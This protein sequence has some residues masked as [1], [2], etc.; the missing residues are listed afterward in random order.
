[1]LR[2]LHVKDLVIV[3][4]LALEL[5][6]GM[7]ALTGETGAGKSIL[8]DALG[9]A[10][11]EKAD[12]A[13]IRA[14]RERAEVA[15]VFDVDRLPAVRQWL[16]ERDLGTA[17]CILRRVVPREGRSRAFVNGSPVPVQTLRELG[18]LL[19]DIHGQHAHQ[20]LLH[21]A[22]QRQLLDSYAGH[23][24]A[25][26]QVAQRYADYRQA[27]RQLDDLTAAAADRAN[28][29]DFL[30]YQVQEL[31]HGAQPAE[32]L[33]ALDEEQRRLAHAER[34]LGDTAALAESL[35][36]ADDAVQ[37]VLARAV[38]QLD[39]LL[40]F[41]PALS[42][43]RELLE[44]ARIQVEEAA[45]TL[46]DYAGRIELDPERLQQVE[47]QLERIHQLAR[48]HRVPPAGL[49]AHLDALRGE[50]DRLQHADET[51]AAL[52]GRAETLQRDY[53]EA[54]GKLSDRR[55]RAGQRLAQEVTAA[56]QGLAMRGGRFDVAVRPLPEAQAGAQG[57]DE[58]EFLVTANPGQPL[59]PLSR[60]ASGGE[61]SRIS[62]AIQVASAGCGEVP[63][64][65]FDE[66]DVGIG[67][68]VAEIVGRLLRQLGE[69]RQVLCVTHLPQ[70]AAQSHQHLQVAKR[71]DGK[72][73]E[74]GIAPLEAATRIQ[75]I[76]RMLGGVDI[77]EQT[78]AHAAEMIGRAGSA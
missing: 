66:V 69:S 68:A 48:K 43:S 76:A 14:G 20:S 13:L 25:L 6:P 37:R 40:P 46:R 54:A 35:Y 18:A 49:A 27:R 64:L 19:V 55:R 34:L 56:M 36:E 58:V 60:V 74:T 61:L 16:D 5:E 52:Q 12:G 7:T 38:Q 22:A 44:S 39:E 57:L 23:L 1:M 73:T 33:E 11:G 50:L 30:R 65:I 8:I 41:D 45:G 72:H 77:T 24:D 42:E 32:A 53:L 26:A 4:R 9:L 62:L 67:G 70:V 15:A 28:R 71:T 47:E 63:T 17:E 59:A 75:E 51:L 78:L 3:R 21:R 29:L 31:E 2:Q 10:L